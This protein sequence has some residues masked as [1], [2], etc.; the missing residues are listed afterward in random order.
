MT[1]GQ[2]PDLPRVAVGAVVVHDGA[3]LLVRRGRPPNLGRWAIPGG[4]V[5]LGE[6]LT[7]AAEREIL[8]ET[9]VRIRAAEP[10][11]VFD[12]VTR[13]DDGRVAW[14]YVIVD[15]AARYLSGEPAG[16]DD[17]LEAAWVRPSELEAMDVS[18]RT[19]ELLADTPGFDYAGG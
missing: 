15:L 17:A 14:H 8:E 13:D 6:T 3:V 10:V 11:F 7:E 19:L 16:A 5:R 12:S 18:E 9:G 1:T 4:S 2:Y